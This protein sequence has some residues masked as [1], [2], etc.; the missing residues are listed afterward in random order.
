MRFYLIS[1]AIT[2]IVLISMISY[3]QDFLHIKELPYDDEQVGL[4]DQITIHF[5]H[6]VAE[7][8]P[9]GLA[10]TK[11][12]Q[13]VAEK[14]DGKI[15]VQI[16]PNGV[17][18]NDDNEL[19]ALQKGDIQM[20]APTFSK[21]TSEL[22]S[23]QV[24]DLPYMIENE[25]QIY[26]VLHGELSDQLLAELETIQVK[27]LTFWS[28][29]FKQMAA[30]ST[31]ILSVKDFESLRVRTMASSI[32]ERQFT[33]LG[34]KPIVISFNELYNELQN[35]Q[36][37]AQENTISNLYSKGYYAIQ[38]H[39]TLSNHGILGYA[40]MMNGPFWKSLDKSSQQIITEAL[41]EMT[42]WQHQQ[43]VQLNVQNLLQLQQKSDVHLYELT[44]EQKQ[45]WQEEL[46][47]LFEQYKK[48]NKNT[49]VQQL[50]Q[51]IDSGQNDSK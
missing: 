50:L 45:Q 1:A 17:L 13:L 46:S 6:V 40:V 5:S 31:P 19:Q 10:A 27:G 16:Y 37:I 32:L 34:A 47:P 49:Y 18:Y 42:E 3:N 20:I 9:K 8:T 44:P 35:E 21:V 24:L 7:N 29:G 33:L 23:W 38:N 2:I 41:N 43:A 39:I 36:I 12:A 48:Q 22:P 28:N 15:N 14:S 51:E 25:Q 26:S 30:K 4:N 11:F